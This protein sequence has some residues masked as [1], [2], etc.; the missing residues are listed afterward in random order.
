MVQQEHGLLGQGQPFQAVHQALAGGAPEDPVFAAATCV[1]P[2]RPGCGRGFPGRGVA[3]A[4]DADLAPFLAQAVD[5][6]VVCQREEPGPPGRAL[7]LP[8]VAGLDG[9]QPGVLEHLV[10]LGRR[11]TA[12]QPA[13]ETVQRCL[14]AG[15]QRLEGAYVAGGEGAHQLVVG[16]LGHHGLRLQPG[17][18]AQRSRM[19]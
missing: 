18:Y 13:H 12:E 11:G 15:V 6:P 14:V 17:L 2:G 5:R 9:A 7:G 3:V 1:R 19:G 10:G 4:F 8:G 16:R